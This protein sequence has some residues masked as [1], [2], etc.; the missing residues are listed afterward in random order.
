MRHLVLDDDLARAG[1]VAGTGHWAAGQ[2]H[3][4]EAWA[5]AVTEFTSPAKRP[6]PKGSGASQGVPEAMPTPT[7][8]TFRDTPTM[9][10]P[11]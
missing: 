1:R 7:H 3:A 11:S 2:R 10:H 5:K 6:E 4:P 9:A 8:E